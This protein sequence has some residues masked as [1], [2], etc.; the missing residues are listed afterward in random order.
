MRYLKTTY[1]KCKSWQNSTGAG[2][3]EEDGVRTIAGKIKL[4]LIDI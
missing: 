3:E 2:V 1:L 4:C